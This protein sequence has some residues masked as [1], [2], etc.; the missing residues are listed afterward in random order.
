MAERVAQEAQ[1][2]RTQAADPYLILVTR[3]LP[4]KERGLC[5]LDDIAL[6][7][8]AHV[9][10][11]ASIVRRWLIGAHRA[12]TTARGAPRKA[13]RLYAYLA[14]EV[15]RAEWAP[16]LE[17]TSDLDTKL[18]AERDHH[19]RM[20]GKRGHLQEQLRTAHLHINAKLEEELTEETE[21]VAS[22]GQTTL[23]GTDR[24]AA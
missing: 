5:V 4:A 24:A 3:K 20:W 15:F 23:N 11:V 7:E 19:E 6:C 2:R 9:V 16:I 13:Q 8:P 10:A 22:I 14:G 21:Q 1:E 12:Q 18:L 17:C